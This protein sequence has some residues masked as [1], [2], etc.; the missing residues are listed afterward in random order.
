[1]VDQPLDGGRMP[2]SN[3]VSDANRPWKIA[4]LFVLLSALGI[5]AILF[6]RESP[7]NGNAQTITLPDEKKDEKPPS[8][9]FRNWDKPTLAIAFTGQM[10]GYLQ[11]CGCSYP[12]YG[13]L[14]RRF[15]FLKSLRDKGWP[16]VATDLGDLAP[17]KGPQ[18]LLKYDT[19][20][21]ALG[22]MK[23]SGISLGKNEFYL[24]LDEAL[25]VPLNNKLAPRILAANLNEDDLGVLPWKIVKEGNVTIGLTGVIGPGI[26]EEGKT[27]FK[28]VKFNPNAGKQVLSDLG[29]HKPDIVMILYQGSEDEAKA[30][31]DICAKLRKTNPQIPKVDAILCLEKE[32][33]PAGI[34]K[35]QGDT[36]IFGIGHKGRYVG[37]L[38][39]FRN[40]DDGPFEL[41]YQLVSIGPEWDTPK[42]KEK[43]NP[44]M[45]LM[46]EY[47]KKVKDRNYLTKYPRNK[48]PVQLGSENA[49][50]I[51]SDACGNCHAHAYKIWE[52]KDIKG[53]AH[54]RAFKSLEEAKHPSLRQFDGECVSCH[55]VG[56]QY[57][58]GYADPANNERTNLKLLNVGCES[59]HGPGSDH[60][61]NPNNA[62]IR[63]LI[64]PF[65]AKPGE[66]AAA[67]QLRLNQMDHFCQKCHDIDNDV[68]WGKVPFNVQWQKIAHPTPKKEVQVGGG[69]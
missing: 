26:I 39:A 2:E 41:K 24:P 3:H 27:K 35:K 29:S 22:L 45:V 62:Q 58:T 1:M 9:L 33:E 52:A 34:A 32:E 37:V 66:G 46:E 4:G 61:D 21:S 48:H 16:L 14:A 67:K 25:V 36:L 17:R 50:Y 55:V 11:P 10:Y 47:A 7:Q 23:Y 6:L 40:K 19:A 38:G 42:G 28:D 64:N 60:A 65:K 59:C 12:Q 51:G 30:C 57:N 49:K 63:A 56:F 8:P 18:A 13:G 53:L 31:A 68:N 20:M 44:V 43:D 54:S 69:K 15:N 5:G